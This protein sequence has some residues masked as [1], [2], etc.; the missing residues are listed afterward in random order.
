MLFRSF[1]L[2]VLAAASRDMEGETGWLGSPW[3][4]RLGH[5]SFAW[6]LVHEIVIRSLLALGGRP[7]GLAETAGVWLVALVVSQALAGLLY[8]LVEHPTERRLRALVGD[9]RPVQ[10]EAAAP[11]ESPERLA[12]R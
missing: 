7:Q 12:A 3:L 10:A 1:L 8:T 5:W 9:G 2:A 4:I 6:Y 11:S